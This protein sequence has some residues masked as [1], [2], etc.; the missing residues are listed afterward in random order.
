MIDFA[1]TPEGIA[2]HGALVHL[3]AE[4]RQSILEGIDGE[5]GHISDEDLRLVLS[6]PGLLDL[7]PRLPHDMEDD[8][9]G[10]ITRDDADRIAEACG[11]Y[12]DGCW[13]PEEP[14]WDDPWIEFWMAGYR[15]ETG[16]GI[17]DG[18][19]W[20]FVRSKGY[21]DDVGHRQYAE[22]RGPRPPGPLTHEEWEELCRWRAEQRRFGI[23]GLRRRCVQ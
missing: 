7:G 5:W 4:L 13:L 15:I 23:E 10:H 1:T 2:R 18:D 9:Y 6:V 11:L 3:V 21:W 22:D 17:L 16:E 20:D 12:L 8:G 19:G 14:D